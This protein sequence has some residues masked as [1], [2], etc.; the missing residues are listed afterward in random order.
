MKKIICMALMCVIT[1]S[2]CGCEKKEIDNSDSIVA[3]SAEN[4]EQIADENSDGEKLPARDREV[5]TE[6]EFVFDDAGVLS[7]EEYESINTYTAWVAQT[8]R[9][10]AS[11]VITDNIEEK[12]PE[13]FAK[14]YY[15]RL[16]DGDGVLFLLNNDTNYDCLYRAGTPARFISDEDVQMLFAEISP[17]IIM[18][19]YI[20]AVSD[21]W[22]LAEIK[23]PQCVTDLTGEIDNEILKSADEILKEA[24]DSGVFHIIYLTDSGEL[25]LSDFT[26]KKFE[27]FYGNDSDGVMLVVNTDTGKSGFMCKGEYSYLEKSVSDIKEDV[28]NCFIKDENGD[29]SFDYEGVASAVISY[30]E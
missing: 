15:E 8:F 6:T 1:F 24:D 19:D 13:E 30:I 29:V 4:T 26:K 11:V 20:G 17:V 27:K 28:V 7:D 9:I 18:E 14:E 21:V 10:N 16:Y 3:E 12:S 22:E 23:I 2:V 25:S 5:D